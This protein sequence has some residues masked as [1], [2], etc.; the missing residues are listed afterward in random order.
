VAKILG[1]VTPPQEHERPLARL[2]HP[3]REIWLSARTKTERRRARACGKEPW[4]VDWIE[5]AVQ[6]GDVFY[7][8]GANA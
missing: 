4:T 1:P 3:Q 5:T 8:V 2:D 6:P 7:D